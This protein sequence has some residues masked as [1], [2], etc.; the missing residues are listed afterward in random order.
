VR[1]EASPGDTV[2]VADGAVTAEVVDLPFEG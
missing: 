2:A 1:R